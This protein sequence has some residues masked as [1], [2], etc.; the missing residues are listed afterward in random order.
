[1]CAQTAAEAQAGNFRLRTKQ[2]S[3]E[4]N[5]SWNVNSALRKHRMHKHKTKIKEMLDDNVGGGG[6]SAEY[7]WK[8]DRKSLKEAP[9][10]DFTN[11][12]FGPSMCK[13]AWKDLSIAE[14]YS[15][16]GQGWGT[17]PAGV[18]RSDR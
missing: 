9:D 10:M 15:Y 12:G 11:C 8:Q 18:K 7:D 2:L 6:S 3:D 5:K 17:I 4:A 1:M 14:K 13:P 16:L